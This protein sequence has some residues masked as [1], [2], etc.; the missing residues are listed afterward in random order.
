MSAVNE[1]ARH[2]AEAAPQNDQ[3]RM[4]VASDAVV[5]GSADG[6]L[7]DGERAIITMNSIPLA[8]ACHYPSF[9]KGIEAM[10][11]GLARSGSGCCCGGSCSCCGGKAQ[12]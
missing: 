2:F 7:D 4:K 12:G 11:A 10:V 6:T 5:L 1:L 8:E 9:R 3:E